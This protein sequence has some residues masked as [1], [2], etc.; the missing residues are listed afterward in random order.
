VFFV[1]E[2]FF[3]DKTKDEAKQGR[4]IEHK[5]RELPSFMLKNH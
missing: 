2:M 3:E 1:L 4:N 5:G